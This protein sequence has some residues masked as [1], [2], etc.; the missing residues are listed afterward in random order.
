[1]KID[2]V[3]DKEKQVDLILLQVKALWECDPISGGE[4]RLVTKSKASRKQAPV[5]VPLNPLNP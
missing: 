4:G 3:Q 2:V 5:V 1:M